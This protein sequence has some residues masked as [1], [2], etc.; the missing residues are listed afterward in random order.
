MSK[1]EYLTDRETFNRLWKQAV[2]GRE[3]VVAA[4]ESNKAIFFD[5]SDICTM[6]YHNFLRALL[7]E[8]GEVEFAALVLR[9]DPET[10]FY[11]HFARY[12]AFIFG[13]DHSDKDF[14][15][16]LNSDPGGSLA[17]A[18]DAN[19]ERYIV[20]PLSGEWAIYAD[21]HQELSAMAGP[22]DVLEFARQHYPFEVQE[23]NPGFAIGD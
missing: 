17:D 20:F 22:R 7:T 11:H 10:Y 18:F 13:P 8:R 3:L 4:I 9:P 2:A 12:P 15:V 1:S 21:R 16:S 6:R 14:V 23:K 5:S 19:S